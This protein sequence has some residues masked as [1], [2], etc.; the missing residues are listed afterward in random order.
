VSGNVSLYNETKA[1]D[2]SSVA[3]LPTPAIGGV[4]LLDDWKKSA[5]IG[6]KAEGEHILLISINS[7][8][9]GLGQSLWL[10]EI[11]GRQDGP[12]PPV[13][14]SAERHYGTA[15]RAYIEAGLFSAVHD[16]SDGGMLVALAE[17]SLAS[18]I[19][20]EICLRTSRDKIGKLERCFG[21]GQSSYLATVSPSAFDGR[22]YDG[23]EDIF[24]F[25]NHYHD[26]GLTS[27]VIGATAGTEIVVYEEEKLDF[28]LWTK[29]RG[30]EYREIELARIPLAELRAAHEGF[31]PKLMGSELTPEF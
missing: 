1:E 16:I 10:Q 3:I 26:I 27:S 9:V 6:F 7:A 18:G 11:C 21:E 14:L 5:T 30:P 8:N 24:E 20:A 17:M 31:F 28:R 12:P 23:C 19:G 13:T 25:L 29:G 4:G 2:G 15:V 22:R